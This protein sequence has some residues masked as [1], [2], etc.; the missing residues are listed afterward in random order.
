MR[1]LIAL[2]L[3][4]VNCGPGSSNPV[5][6]PDKPQPEVKRNLHTFKLEGIFPTNGLVI[7]QIKVDAGTPYEKETFKYHEGQQQVLEVEGETL[8]IAT[9]YN[10]TCMFHISPCPTTMVAKFSIDGVLVEQRNVNVFPTN[11]TNFLE[12]QE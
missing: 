6:N 2:F 12:A 8:N 11:S 1:Y 3:I 9:A 10:Y 7:L 5:P 4:L